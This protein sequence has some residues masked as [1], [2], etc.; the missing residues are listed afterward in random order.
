MSS[1]GP[2]LDALLAPGWLYRVR[3]SRQAALLSLMAIATE[4]RL[5]LAPILDAFADD[6]K[7]GWRRRIRDLSDMLQSGA[8]LPDAL[9]AV[10]GL[11]PDR[12][13]MSIRVGA[14]SG[15]VV[16]ALKLAA[17][18]LSPGRPSS[19]ASPS[20]ILTYLSVLAIVMVAIISYMMIEIVPKLARIFEGFG[21]ELPELTQFIIAASQS[22]ATYGVLAVPLLIGLGY[23]ASV[24]VDF[25]EASGHGPF[26][27]TGPFT[28]PSKWLLRIMPRIASGGILRSLSIAVAAGRPLAGALSTMAGTHPVPVVRRRIS[29]V[30]DDV[31][32]GHDCWQSMLAT[33]LIGRREATLLEAAERAGNLD[34]ALRQ[35][36]SGADSRVSYRFSAVAEFVRPLLLLLVAVVVGIFVVGM[37]LPLVK[38][39]ND[40]S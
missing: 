19:M 23:L 17:E 35:V 24:L 14:E 32:R 9:E 36:A 33:G 4:R 6:S 10:P 31:E 27:F 37:F 5:P 13:V 1:I 29:R 16:P 39:L 11:L 21:T 34:W 38:L 26:P 2:H 8:S 40:L 18:Q 22:A 30:A 25:A 12:V 7:T 3:N 28:G 20:G 15:A